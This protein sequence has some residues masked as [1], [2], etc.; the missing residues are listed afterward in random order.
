[1]TVKDHGP[2]GVRSTGIAI[3]TLSGAFFKRGGLFIVD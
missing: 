1:M 2:K 3:I